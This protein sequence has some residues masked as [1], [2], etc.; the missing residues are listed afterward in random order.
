LTEK[1]GDP[2]SLTYQLPA[3]ALYLQKHEVQCYRNIKDMLQLPS[4]RV[5]GDIQEVCH[6]DAKHATVN[7]LFQIGESQ[8][9]TFHIVLDTSCHKQTHQDNNVLDLQWNKC[10]TRSHLD[11]FSTS[12]KA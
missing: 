9:T 11:V 1:S 10:V 12:Y 8:W 7:R 6:S 2:T 3:D 4:T 5:D